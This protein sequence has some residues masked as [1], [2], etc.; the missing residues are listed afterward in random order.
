MWFSREFWFKFHKCLPIFKLVRTR[1]RRFILSRELLTFLFTFFTI[2]PYFL[3]I[4]ELTLI[5]LD[6]FYSIFRTFKICD[7]SHKHLKY[8]YLPKFLNTIQVSRYIPT[9]YKKKQKTDYFKNS[10]NKNS[11]GKPVFTCQ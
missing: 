11:E 9:Q 1:G 4:L 3:V 8:R 7:C 5:I 6:I 10:Q 2:I